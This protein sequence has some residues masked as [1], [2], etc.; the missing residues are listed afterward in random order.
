MFTEADLEAL[1][2]RKIFDR[3][4][5]YYCEYDAVGKIKQ[6]GNIFKAKVRG[7]ETYRVEL[8]IAPTGPPKIYC[9]CPYDYGDVC[10]HGIALG[11]AVLDLLGEE[12]SQPASLSATPKPAAQPTKE[13]LRKAL[14]AAFSRTS[15]KEKIAYLG[16]L[17]YQQ[18]TLIPEFLNTFGF[19]LELLLAAG[20]APKPKPA[21][22][23]PRRPPTLSEQAHALLDQQRGPELLPLL[24]TVHWLRELPAQ[25]SHILPSLLAKAAQEQPEATL[26]A[27]M[28]RFESYLADKPLRSAALYSRLAACLKEL[29]TLPGLAKQVQLFASE[30]LRQYSRLSALCTSLA[31]AGFT[32][33]IPEQDT[34]LPPN[35][36]GRKRKP[37]TS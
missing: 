22:T 34:G 2:P 30:L 3:G 35:Q 12:E 21:P 32:M 28:E 36:R 9:D 5:A 23:A 6:K 11:L 19:S 10:K 4:A 16:Q 18:P 8:T 31:T 37:I 25:D 15:D 33:L 17:L 29:A 24:L 26:D 13:Q 20:P 1:V 27:V 7:T 14:I